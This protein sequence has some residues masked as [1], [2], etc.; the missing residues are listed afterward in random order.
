MTQGTTSIDSVLLRRALGRFTTGVTVITTVGPEGAPAG[1]TASA[2]SALSLAPPLVLVC[3][4]KQRR[5]H[6]TLS[7]APGYAVNILASHQS[8]LAT[9]F[10]RPAADRFAGVSCSPGRHGIPLISGVLA[11]LQCDRHSQLDGGDHSIVLGHV[12]DIHLGEGKP[13]LYSEGTF[14]SLPDEDWERSQTSARH[15]WL[16]S[17]PW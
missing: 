3:M 8:F 2:F 5:M 17:A 11:H 15:E 10:A 16:L 14:F 13:L 6:D 7:S 12:R 4:G 1:C 9:K